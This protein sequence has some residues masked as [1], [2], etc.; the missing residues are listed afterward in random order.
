MGAG[1]RSVLGRVFGC[2]CG[3]GR[4]GVLVLVCCGGGRDAFLRWGGG[5]GAPFVGVGIRHGW[6]V[7]GGGG[8]VVRGGGAGAVL[9][10]EEVSSL[11]GC[12]EGAGLCSP[13]LG[14]VLGL[15]EGLVGLLRGVANIA[16]DAGGMGV[17]VSEGGCVMETLGTYPRVECRWGRYVLFADPYVASFRFVDDPGVRASIDY[18]PST[19]YVT[20]VYGAGSPPL[21]ELGKVVGDRVGEAEG[22]VREGARKLALAALFP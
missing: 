4:C 6:L 2:V 21:K 10:E 20:I 15:G 11:L 12:V 18:Y 9:S 5:S 7:C 3:G 19:G 17:K 14:P 22:S 8:C 16:R 1:L 13:D